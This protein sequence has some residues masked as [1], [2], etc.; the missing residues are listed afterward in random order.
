[1]HDIARLGRVGVIEAHVE[2]DD[3]VGRTFADIVGKRAHGR[4][5]AHFIDDFRHRIAAPLVGVKV[6]LLDQ[7]D[8]VAA[9]EHLFA[10][11]GDSLADR[12][13][14]GILRD[15]LRQIL[16]LDQQRSR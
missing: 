2:R 9:A 7:R 12:P 10:D 6:V 4:R 5:F 1:M 14:V 13:A 3:I 8:Q 11:L 15:I 16:W